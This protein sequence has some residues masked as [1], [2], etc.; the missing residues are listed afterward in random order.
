ME[1]VSSQKVRNAVDMP[2]NDAGAW[3]N[4][5]VV[6][7]LT[8]DNPDS[9]SEVATAIPGVVQVCQGASPRDKLTALV[10]T[11]MLIDGGSY[12][13]Y[14]FVRDHV[15]QSREN[16]LPPPDGSDCDKAVRWIMNEGTNL[17][18]DWYPGLSPA[19]SYAEV[20][21]YLHENGKCP[22]PCLGSEGVTEAHMNIPFKVCHNAIFPEPCAR[23]IRKLEQDLEANPASFPDLDRKATPKDLQ[24]CRQKTIN[25]H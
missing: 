2:N 14:A 13:L 15:P 10:P 7:V 1:R 9:P 23:Q 6:W 12:R 11:Q 24:I 8:T 25:V 20:Q 19:S 22:S 5:D 4:N 17:H 16:C 18:A 21:G 3:Q